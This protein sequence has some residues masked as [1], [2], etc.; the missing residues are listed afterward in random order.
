V[1]PGL[2]WRQEAG[3]GGPATPPPV[4]SVSPVSGFT[5]SGRRERLHTER[6]LLIEDIDNY[7]KVLSSEMDPA[8]IRLIR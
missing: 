6:L 8:K 2:G 3:A 7:L 4:P 5:G 1:K